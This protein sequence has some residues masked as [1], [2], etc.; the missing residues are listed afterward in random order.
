[1][2][3]PAP[4]KDP[5]STFQASHEQLEKDTVFTRILTLVFFVIGGAVLGCLAAAFFYPGITRHMRFQRMLEDTPAKMKTRMIIGGVIGAVL[6]V[7]F[8][9]KS[10]RSARD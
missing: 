4:R 1:M 6:A 2:T 3:P 7:S 8:V 5:W 10:W 9:I